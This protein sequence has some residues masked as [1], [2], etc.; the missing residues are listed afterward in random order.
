MHSTRGEVCYNR[1]GELK[2]EAKQTQQEKKKFSFSIRRNVGC[3]K[4]CFLFA[5]LQYI[6]IYIYKE[7]ETERDRGMNSSSRLNS[8]TFNPAN[9]DLAPSTENVEYVTQLLARVHLQ[10]QDDRA[11]LEKKKLEAN[12]QE[13]DEVKRA[14]ELRN[15]S[16]QYYAALNDWK[17]AAV[18]SKSGS[19]R[20][21]S[22][23]QIGLPELVWNT[24]KV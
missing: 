5:I 11:N 13:T 16:L 9:N 20:T 7:R 15:E 2:E 18:L 22:R 14:R 6:Y 23:T 3:D 21:M 17:Q 8:R 4:E 1:T 12:N 10:L 19:N 24:C